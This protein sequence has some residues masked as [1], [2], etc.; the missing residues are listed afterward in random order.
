M[1]RSVTVSVTADSA[2][3]QRQRELRSSSTSVPLLQRGERRH[4]IGG[5]S[6]GSCSSREGAGKEELSGGSLHS[7]SRS[8]HSSIGPPA[9]QVCV[10]VRVCMRACVRVCVCVCVCA[11]VHACV[12]ACVCVRVCVC[13]H[14]LTLHVLATLDRPPPLGRCASM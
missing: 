8:S 10:R 12:R 13:T 7:H 9:G 11:C 2:L 5:A 6:V 3:L 1:R 14:T 4:G